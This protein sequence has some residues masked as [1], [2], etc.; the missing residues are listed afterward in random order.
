MGETVAAQLQIYVMNRVQGLG[1]FQPTSFPADG[2]NVGKMVEGQRR[3]TQ[4]G[5]AVYTVIPL[6]FTLKAIKGGTLTVGPYTANATLEL[7]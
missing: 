4:I 7:P 5:N 2:F 1:G 6:S 3:Q